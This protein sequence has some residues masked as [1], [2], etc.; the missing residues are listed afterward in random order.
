LGLTRTT[1]PKL[2]LKKGAMVNYNDPHVP[3]LPPMR[4]YPHLRMASQ[5]LTVEYLSSQDCVLIVKDHSA[6][7][8]NWIGQHAPLIVDTRNA[9]KNANSPRARVI[10]A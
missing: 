4:D 7:D 5:E 9:M 3:V 6:Y 1:G 10:R 8:W 2:L